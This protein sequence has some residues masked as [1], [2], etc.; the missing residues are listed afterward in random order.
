MRRTNCIGEYDGGSDGLEGFNHQEENEWVTVKGG[1]ESRTTYVT[2]ANCRR[3]WSCWPAG[4]AFPFREPMFCTTE[5]A[6]DVHW[7]K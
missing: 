1:K 6:D 4:N 5:L 7:V 2:L 3:T